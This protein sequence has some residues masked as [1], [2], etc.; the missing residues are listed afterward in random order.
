MSVGAGPAIVL[1]R[2]QLAENIGAAARAMLN[3][4][5]ADLRLVRPRPHWPH[6]RAAAAS[7]GA[8]QVLATA[9]LYD[10][11]A[12]AVADCTFVLATTARSRDQVKPGF[13]A[14]EAAARARARLASGDRIAILFGPERTGLENDEIARANALVQVP[15]NPDFSSLNL[16]QAVLVIAYEWRLATSPAP[17]GARSEPPAAHGEVTGFLDRLIEALDGCG[18]LRHTQMR[19]TMVRNIENMFR[20]VDLTEQEVRTLHGILTCLTRQPHAS[21]AG[22]GDRPRSSRRARAR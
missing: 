1:V 11:V 4:G 9:R 17:K 3:C 10:D 14:R 21:P 6:P 16:A 18:F 22:P 12:S 13:D 8:D 20:R 15:L 5:L 19:P 7:A 2:P